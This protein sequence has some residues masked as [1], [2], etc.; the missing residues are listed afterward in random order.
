MQAAHSEGPLRCANCPHEFSSLN[1]LMSH[2]CGSAADPEQTDQTLPPGGQANLSLKLTEGTGTVGDE[3]QLRHQVILVQVDTGEAV[4]NAAN[5]AGHDEAASEEF[6]V[7]DIVLAASR[8][9]HQLYSSSLYHGGQ[10]DQPC[11][12]LVY[13]S[14][15]VEIRSEESHGAMRLTIVEATEDEDTSSS[16]SKPIYSYLKS[17]SKSPDQSVSSLKELP[18]RRGV[19]QQTAVY[20]K[21]LRDKEEMLRGN[22]LQTK[23]LPLRQSSSS[24][25]RLAKPVTSPNKKTT[26]ARPDVKSIIE[27][28]TMQRRRKSNRVRSRPEKPGEFATSQ[29]PI[30][31]SSPTGDAAAN[32]PRNTEVENES[33][34]MLRN[35][36]SGGT[37]I[38]KETEV[39]VV[40]GESQNLEYALLQHIEETVHVVVGDQH[41]GEESDSQ[42]NCSRVHITNQLESADVVQPIES[43]AACPAVVV[44]G[45]QP[46]VRQPTP[47]S[48]TKCEKTFAKKSSLLFHQGKPTEMHLYK[49]L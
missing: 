28:Y 47:W 5:D 48:C 49:T 13:V 1:Q 21:Q 14:E 31:N 6:I 25:P 7:P 44:V 26:F 34:G 19:I 32:D 2:T 41:Q 15:E 23:S 33:T 22:E 42:R 11:G 17:P 46:A 45:V 40:D 24:S 38:V 12:G 27:S 4:G 18:R 8:T 30:V 39:S 35:E 9:D 43:I 29:P 3:Q 36:K 20:L 16:V 37:V 10:L